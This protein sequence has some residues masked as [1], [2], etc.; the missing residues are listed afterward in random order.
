MW[1]VNTSPEELPELPPK[2][3][4]LFCLYINISDGSLVHPKDSERFYQFIRHCHARRVKLSEEGLYT[5]LKRSGC[6]EDQSK[7][8][9]SIYKHGRG[10]LRASLPA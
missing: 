7:L 8:L 5:I 3:A 1:S 10:L 6:S 9:S 4:Q 2:A